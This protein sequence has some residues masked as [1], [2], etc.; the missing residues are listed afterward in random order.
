[1]GT[2]IAFYL[3]KEFREKMGD[4]W[5]PKNYVEETIE[6]FGDEFIKKFAFEKTPD[7]SHLKKIYDPRDDYY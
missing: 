4:D 5:I 2:K 3:F 1:M 7:L 6:K